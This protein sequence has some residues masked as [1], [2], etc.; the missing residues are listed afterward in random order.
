[1][2][3]QRGYGPRQAAARNRLD[4]GIAGAGVAGFSDAMTFGGGDHVVAGLGAFAGSRDFSDWLQRYRT[5]AALEKARDDFDRA[6][7]P[8]ARLAGEVAGTGTQLVAL[9]PLDGALAGG[10]GLARLAGVGRGARLAERTGMK[11]HE[12]GA[13]GLGGAGAGVGGQAISDLR[14]QRLGSAGDYI[15][16]GAG[17]FVDAAASPWIGP[18]KAGALG[19]AT[20]SMLQDALNGRPVSLEDAGRSA[21]IAGGIGGVVGLGVRGRTA[22]MHFRQKGKVGERISPFRTIIGA[23]QPLPGKRRYLP[24]GRRTDTDGESLRGVTV[25][26]K[27]G[28]GA[29]LSNNQLEAM[30]TLPKYRVDH[31]LFNDI[32]S[33]IGVPAGLFGFGMTRSNERPRKGIF[34]PVG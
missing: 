2:A 18:G 6:R 30:R 11:L 4:R 1:M 26:A 28:P 17:G 8:R 22:R 21:A 24:S 13:I 5:N 27:T 19:G 29:E 15:G 34:Q 20:T 32:G 16:A 9:G 14:S 25:E 33:L 10:A 23:D 7:H 31:Y 12:L 3:M